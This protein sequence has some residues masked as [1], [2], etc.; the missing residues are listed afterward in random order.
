MR[1]LS[2]LACLLAPAAAC[3]E[4]PSALLKIVAGQCVPHAEASGDPFPC[5]TV[6]IAGGVDKGYAVLKDINGIAQY[7]LIPTARVT[8][9]DD[10]AILAQ[11][12]PN[13]WQAAWDNRHYIENRL[14]TT[15]PRDAIS[16]AINSAS[17]RTQD[18]L[19]I[20]IDCISPG[21]QD[22]LAANGGT[23]TAVWAPFPLPL[24]GHSYRAI[25]IDQDTLDGVN[26]FHVLADASAGIDMGQHTLVAVGAIF[27]DGKNGFILL[28]DHVDPVTADLAS[29][30]ELQDHTCKIARG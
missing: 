19:H 20:H 28:D 21:V 16:L 14:N 23:V 24:Q 22:T 8:G 29:G 9:I 25:R 5:A 10:P 30:E 17:G 26:P 6:N 18:Q 27:P 12:S 3:A 4:D 2:L 15:L 11:G 13:Y 1:V 7:L